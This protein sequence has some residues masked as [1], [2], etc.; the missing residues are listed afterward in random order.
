M[1]EELAKA[2]ESLGLE[3]YRRHIF[4]C[5]DQGEPKCAPRKKTLKAWEFLKDKGTSNGVAVPQYR[6]MHQL[7][8]FSDVWDF[9]KKW[10]QP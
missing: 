4:L 9:E 2:V 8:G 3:R 1:D 6:D 7:M 5:A 10:A